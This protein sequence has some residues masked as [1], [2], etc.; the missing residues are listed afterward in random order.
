MTEW[1]PKREWREE[2][3]KM[4]KGKTFQVSKQPHLVFGDTEGLLPPPLPPT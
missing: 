1:K 4:N 2:I 3:E